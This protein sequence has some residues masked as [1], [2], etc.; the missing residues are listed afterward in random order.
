[1]LYTFIYV[2]TWFIERWFKGIKGKYADL[3]SAD[4]DSYFFSS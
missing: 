3:K 4:Y 1:M 2:Y